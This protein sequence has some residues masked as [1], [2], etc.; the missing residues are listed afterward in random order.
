VLL[1]LNCLAEGRNDAAGMVQTPD[2]ARVIDG[3]VSVVALLIHLLSR[4]IGE[5]MAT[6]LVE[7]AWA[8]N[9]SEGSSA[10]TRGVRDG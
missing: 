9:P 6:R 7:Q 5:E 8:A 1:G 10:E 3:F 4:V 2:V